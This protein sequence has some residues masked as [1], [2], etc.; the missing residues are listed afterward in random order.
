MNV[1][2][3][4]LATLVDI[5]GM[6]AEDM[7]ETLTVDGIPVEHVV[8]PAKG[9]SNVKTGKILEIEKHPDANK[10]VVCQ[11]DI[12]EKDTIQIVT[13]ASNVKV[14]QIVP[15]ALHGAHLPAKH[16]ASKPGGLAKGDIKIKKSKLRGVQS[17]GMMCSVGE[18]GLDSNLF[19]GVESEGIM[20][21]PESTPVGIDFTTLHDLDDVIYEMELTANRADCFSM[22]GMAKEVGAIFK[23]KVN[24]PEISIEEKGETI[25]GRAYLAIENPEYCS[26]FG[27]RLIE[28][29][30]IGR[31]PEWIENRLRSNGIRPINNVVDAANYVMLEMGQPLHTYDYDKISGHS[32]TCR[33]AKKD[34]VII[35]LDEK[36][37][38]LLPTDLVIA[39]EKGPV[40]IAGVMGGLDS[41]VTNKTKN[42][43]LESAVFDS[44]SIRRTS[45]RLGLRSEAS[46]RYEKGV[47]PEASLDALNRFCQILLEQNACTVARDILDLYPVPKEKQTVI[48]TVEEI[49]KYIG[50][51]IPK[52]TI[53]DILT[54]L[55]FTVEE[56]ENKL[57]VEVPLFRLDI[58]SGMPDL[59]EEVARVY[60]Y[61]KIPN[62]TPWSAIVKGRMTKE[63]ETLIKVQN[64]LI[65]NG[66]TETLTYS[67]MHKNALKLLN[68]TEKD[69][70]N[71]A[72]PIINPISEEYPVMRTTLLPGLFRTLKYNLSQK[73]NNLAIFETGKVY[74]P[75]ELPL[76]ELPEEVVMI[77]GLLCGNTENEGYPNEVKKYDFYDVKA[78]VENVFSNIGIKNYEIRRSSHP[79]LHPGISAEFVKDGCVLA[80]FGEIHP[81]VL[82]VLNI[83]EK[84]FGFIME[85]KNL[86][87]YADE[88]IIYSK[89]AKYPAV[90]R[91]LAITVPVS[92][93]NN[94]V[95][96]II[97][98]AAGKYL[99]SLKL[100]DLY[101]GEQI[102]SGYK[103]MA[104]SLKFRLKDRTLTDEEVNQWINKIIEELSKE[105]ISLRE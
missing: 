57:K 37:R 34:E 33:H 78:I 83:K 61:S 67:F 32:L 85:L 87:K 18:L 44:A 72:I 16:D 71:K 35:T 15:V 6:D 17:D 84:V 97:C 76:K 77:S 93:S 47:N 39:D 51:N 59:A 56:K 65:E 86:D 5:Q 38:K 49:N 79:T 48:T 102:K 60:G 46:G 88:K 28:N 55:S 70:V 10:L 43:L 92:K 98:K 14:G 74:Y 1:S 54:R 75:K 40:C 66:M 7:A 95:E 27:L 21:L 89:I 2:L 91:D 30:K 58:E 69:F 101:Q 3:K 26:R 80:I 53:I 63:M 73:N 20:I 22:I 90:E 24:L 29:V 94:Y 41:E 25:K 62:T 19:I 9:I 45:R 23:R 4:W 81:N 96:D 68:Y 11:L 52:E 12:G 64:S 100:F 50:M 104:Y 8:Y 103:S 99:E 13:G 105:D 36:E 31:S 82:D 42:I